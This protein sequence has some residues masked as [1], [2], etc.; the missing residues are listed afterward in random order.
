MLRQ[1][2]AS[3]PYGHVNGMPDAAGGQA[4][5]AVK[6]IR[7]GVA[8]ASGHCLGL[9]GDQPVEG[10]A[11][12]QVQGVSDVEQPLVR[13]PDS[14]VRPVGQPAGCKRSQH[15]HSRKPPRAS[16]RSGSSR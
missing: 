1:C 15:R 16:L 9:T 8:E 6:I 11:R 14:D 5:V 3:R 10:A 2:L 13:F 12:G 4:D 7:Y